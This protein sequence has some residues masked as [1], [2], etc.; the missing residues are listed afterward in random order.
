MH[1]PIFQD[2]MFVETS[3]LTGEGVE[4]VFLK[5]GRTIL[6]KINSGMSLNHFYLSAGQDN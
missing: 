2:L 3:A 6:S 4:E 5:C 1:Y